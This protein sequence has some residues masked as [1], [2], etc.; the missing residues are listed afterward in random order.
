[1]SARSTRFNEFPKNSAAWFQ[2]TFQPQHGPGYLARPRSGQP[3]HTYAAASGRRRDRHRTD[4][5]VEVHRAIVAVKLGVQPAAE[6]ESAPL[7]LGTQGK[8]QNLSVADELLR[9]TSNL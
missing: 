1:M 5:I 4:R 3:H 7:G 6:Y 8:D 2:I 9:P